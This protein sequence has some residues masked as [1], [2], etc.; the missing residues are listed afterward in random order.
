MTATQEKK[1]EGVEWT[2]DLKLSTRC[3]TIDGPSFN[4]WVKAVVG[5]LGLPYDDGEKIV[6]SEDPKWVFGYKTFLTHIMA[7]P[8]DGMGIPMFLVPPSTPK[9]KRIATLDTFSGASRGKVA[10]TTPVTIPHLTEYRFGDGDTWM[11]L[12]PM[13]VMSQ[14]YGIK[15]SKGHVLIGGLGMGWL[16]MRVLDRKKVKDV[17]VVERNAAVAKFFGKRL[18]K[19]YGKRIK[20]VT[21]EFWSYVESLGDAIHTFDSVLV[22]I[23]QY[24]QERDSSKGF[25][26][27]SRTHSCVWGWSLY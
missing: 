12:T 19:R 1:R 24:P 14:R 15:R 7:T 2:E 18:K 22:D 4:K 20:V 27:L 5:Q 6:V 8:Y 10:F 11:S 13:E 3:I 17:V 21:G 16:T 25:Y 9:F 23:W 26:E